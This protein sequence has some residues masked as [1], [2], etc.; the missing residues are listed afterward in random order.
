MKDA[1]LR[2]IVDA[3]LFGLRGVDFRVRVPE[4]AE[5]FSPEDA[6]AY[7]EGCDYPESADDFMLALEIRQMFG[8]RMNTMRMLDAMCGP[9][10]LGRELLQLGAQHVMFHDGDETMI[11]H[12]TSQ[13]FRAM[14]SGQSVGFVTANVHSIPLRDNM[15]DV[16]ICHNAT[17]QLSSTERLQQSLSELLRLTSPGGHVVI[18]DFQRG[19]GTAFLAALEERLQWT[20]P[21]IV[22]LLLPTFQA[23]FSK[24]EFSEV[25]ASIPGIAEW[26]VT[27]AQAPANG[28]EKSWA[29]IKADPIKGH[30][31]DFSPISLRAIAR[32]EEP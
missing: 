12:A 18:A 4:Q 20:K 28:A 3:D 6:R 19:T 10:R 30:L 9:G 8:D 7:I 16:V 1:L 27:D 5:M 22:P 13:A 24:D 32:K 15:F 14:C 17:H 23:A 11:A 21:S 31:L 2:T 26:S 29:R 25:L